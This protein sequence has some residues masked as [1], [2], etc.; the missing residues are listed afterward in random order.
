M[1]SL[2]ITLLIALVVVYLVYLVMG[3]LNL[4]EPIRQV[5]YIIIALVVILWLLRTFG[6]V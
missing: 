2:L 6:I 1:V 5:V 4:P 3:Y